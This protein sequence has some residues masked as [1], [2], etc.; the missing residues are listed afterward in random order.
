MLDR[1]T[2]QWVRPLLETGAQTL[3]QKGIKPDQVTLTGFLAGMIAIPLLANQ[4]YIP[5]LIMILLNRVM[6]GLDGALARLNQ[7]TDAGGFLDI[8]LDFIFYSG[9]VL[10]FALADPAKM[11][12]QLICL[13]SLLWG[14]E[15]VFW[16]MRSWPKSTT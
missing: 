2:T 5:A 14:P 15:Q 11:L 10:G 16:P 1:W 13:F 8:T 12:L 3:S 6:D 4:L 9:V 7:P